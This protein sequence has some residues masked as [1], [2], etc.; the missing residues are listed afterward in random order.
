[1]T[2]R[3]IRAPLL[4][5][6]TILAVGACAAAGPP[7]PGPTHQPVQTPSVQPTPGQTGDPT[8]GES[9]APTEPGLTPPAP[10]PPVATP[11]VEPPTPA[12]SPQVSVASRAQAAAL[13]LESDPRF[14]GL[15]PPSGHRMECCWYQAN[16]AA[17]HYLVTIEIGWGDCPSGCINQH[18]WLYRVDYDGAVT[19]LEQEGDEPIERE[20]PAGTG[21]ATVIIEAVAGPVCPV[22]PFPP[23]PACAPQPVAGSAV[24]V[25]D[26]RG[27]EVNRGWTDDSGAMLLQ[28][29]AGAYFVVAGPVEGLMG[30][31]EPQAFRVAEGTQAY[32]HLEYDTGIR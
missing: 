10:T 8:P 18:R 9:P 6:L 13:V 31:P 17:G 28:L 12:P 27:V 1:M 30:E 22:E 21:P 23:D 25:F 7:S 26:P 14:Y 3:Q 4:V 20:P 16:E 32:V 19:L 29:P 5:A 11:P 15:G 2:F 24:V